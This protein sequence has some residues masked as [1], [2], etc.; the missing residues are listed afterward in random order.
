[1]LEEV[2]VKNTISFFIDEVSYIR[3]KSLALY[4]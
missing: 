1:M 3:V 2:V 4:H